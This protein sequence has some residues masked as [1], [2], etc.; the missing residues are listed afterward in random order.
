MVGGA[1]KG[2]RRPKHDKLMISSISFL[3]QCIKIVIDMPL[4]LSKWEYIAVYIHCKEKLYLTRFH[5]LEFRPENL[6]TRK[7]FFFKNTF[8]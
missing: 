7:R 5:L 2:Q 8:N 4:G 6:P 3:T 1:F